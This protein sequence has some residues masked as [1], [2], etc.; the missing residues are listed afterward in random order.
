MLDQITPVILTLNESS[1]IRRTLDRLKWATDIVILDSHST[2]DT[3]ELIKS[4]PQVRLFQRT[5]DYHASQWN[6]AI[7]ETAVRSNWILALDA[8]YVL[9]EALVIELDGLNLTSGFDAYQVGFQYCA[10]GNRLS[11]ALYPPVT[12]LYR[13]EKATYI[14][15]GHTQRVQIDGDVGSLNGLILHDDRKPLSR[16]LLSQDKYMKLEADL[17]SKKQWREIGCADILRKLLVVAPV[18]VFFYCLLVKRGLLD[19]KAGLYY[20][21]QRALAEGILSIRLIEHSTNYEKK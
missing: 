20:A 19:G 16:W 14:Q 7:N 8:D 15:N 21:I 12:V 2:D 13:R 9:S 10:L 1:N 6:H 18:V 17:L 11:G 5:F 4:Y 3:V